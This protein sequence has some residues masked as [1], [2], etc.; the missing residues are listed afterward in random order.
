M[1]GHRI[2]QFLAERPLGIIVMREFA[3]MQSGQ[4]LVKELEECDVPVVMHD[5]SPEL[6]R[7]DTVSSDH[8]EGSYQ[9]C[10]RLIERGRKRILRFWRVT[11]AV[12]QRPHFL[13]QRDQGYEKAMKEH[14]LEE[15]PAVEVRDII[16]SQR[17]AA[18]Y[19]QQ[20]VR[21]VCGC[22]V[23]HVMGEKRVDA[24]VTTTDSVA[25]CVI[26]ALR[27]MGVRPNV[28]VDVAGYDG[29]VEHCSE[30]QWEQTLPVLTVDKKN[31]EIGRSFVELLMDRAEGRIDT[32]EPV[33]RLIV[34]EIIEL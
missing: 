2:H 26:G 5:A 32:R 34:P 6:G 11:P 28:D 23:E 30:L 12:P 1:A 13:T 8:V 16:Y 4:L 15:L 10:R 7:F 24:I 14:G 27:K 21:H 3:Q 20:Q 33:R 19:F 18:E 17:D 29:Y 22:L 25:M 9:L 31:I